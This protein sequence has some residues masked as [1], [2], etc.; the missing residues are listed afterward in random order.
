MTTGLILSGNHPAAAW[1]ALALLRR[2]REILWADAPAGPAPA[3][4]GLSHA[5]MDP[6]GEPVPVWPLEVCAAR[7]DGLGIWNAGL[8]RLLAWPAVLLDAAR[9]RRELELEMQLLALPRW[10]RSG[11]D[12]AA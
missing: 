8:E 9:L 2:G 1:L 11:L 12:P 6:L 4:S 3:W 5:L 7:L 10:P